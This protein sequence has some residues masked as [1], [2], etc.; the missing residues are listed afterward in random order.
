MLVYQQLR[1]GIST[2]NLQ[3]VESNLITSVGYI[4]GNES[5][6]IASI[7]DYLTKEK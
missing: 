4:G 6:T 1:L 2:T 5:D 7:A 3:S